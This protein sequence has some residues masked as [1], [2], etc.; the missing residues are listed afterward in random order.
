MLDLQVLM[1]GGTNALQQG[2]AMR[3]QNLPRMAAQVGFGV[4]IYLAPS[5]LQ[6]VATAKQRIAH[7]LMVH[8]GPPTLVHLLGQWDDIIR[9]SSAAG[10]SG[11]SFLLL[12]KKQKLLLLLRSYGPSTFALRWWAW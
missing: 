1:A 12:Y 6:H 10:L 3:Q 7:G 4:P 8:I 9:L 2:C 5:P 11:E